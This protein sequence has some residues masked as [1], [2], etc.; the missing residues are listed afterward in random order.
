MAK[1]QAAS[2]NIPQA[3]PVQPTVKS[4]VKP[5]SSGS[6]FHLPQSQNTA[7]LFDKTNYIILGLGALLI[8]LG[9]I[10]MSGGNTDPKVFNEAE[11]YSFR[12]ITL[13]P[14]TIIAGF[15]VIIFAILKKPSSGTEA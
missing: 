4:T 10:L 6:G 14:I 1:N 5:K 11:I 9:F 13:A 15:I 7:M 12:R 2:K 8:F 3:K